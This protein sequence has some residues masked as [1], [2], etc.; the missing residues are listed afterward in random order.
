MKPFLA[1]FT[2]ALQSITDRPTDGRTDGRTDRH[3]GSWGNTRGSSSRKPQVSIKSQ[4]WENIID[5]HLD[6]PTSRPTNRPSSR[7]V[8][9]YQREVLAKT[10]SLYQVPNWSYGQKTKHCCRRPCHCPP[11][12]R[13]PPHHRHHH[14]HLGSWGN[15]RRRS[16]RKPQVSIKS[17][18]WEMSFLL[19]KNDF[20]GIYGLVLV[21]GI[22]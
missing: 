22:K 16:S 3:L 17:Q 19:L 7:I 9:K 20:F 4:S 21:P 11:P 18:S 10:P 2:K 1:F 5:R 15:T 8:G 14:H 13:R 6:R 12:R